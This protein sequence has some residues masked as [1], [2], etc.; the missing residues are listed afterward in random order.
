M[1]M[2]MVYFYV[3]VNKTHFTGADCK[4]TGNDTDAI[5][6]NLLAIWDETRNPEIIKF[7]IEVIAFDKWS[8]FTI[9]AG[10]A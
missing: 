3:V 7:L 4:S 1:R 8:P 6:H 2:I 9:R 10:E 5:F